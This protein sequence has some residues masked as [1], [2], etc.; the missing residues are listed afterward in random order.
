[1]ATAETGLL[2]AAEYLA[3]PDDGRCTELVRGETVEMNLPTPRHREKRAKV[4]DRWNEG[5][6]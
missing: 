3:L 1:M 4:M 6:P 2:T 5:L